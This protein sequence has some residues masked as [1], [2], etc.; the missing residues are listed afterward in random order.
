M[1]LP[2]ELAGGQGHHHPGAAD[3]VQVEE[4]E[5]GNPGDKQDAAARAPQ[6]RDDAQKEAEQKKIRAQAHQG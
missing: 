3:G 6:P 2:Q 1:L 5:A 4:K